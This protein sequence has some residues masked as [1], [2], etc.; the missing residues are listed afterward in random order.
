M[1]RKQYH[2]LRKVFTS[3]LDKRHDNRTFKVSNNDNCADSDKM[4][5]CFI[6]KS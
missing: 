1:Q 4:G 3:T 5:Q 2:A 6:W